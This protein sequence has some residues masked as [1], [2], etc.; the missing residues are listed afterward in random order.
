VLVALSASVAVA[1]SLLALSLIFFFKD[2]PAGPRL[3]KTA[4]AMLMGVAIAGMHYTAM[5]ASTFTR[6]G[7]APDLCHAVSITALGVLGMVIVPIM[8]L[9]IAVSTCSGLR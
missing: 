3:R 4:G 2:K 7:N 6:S 9:A 8:V 5:A 1:G